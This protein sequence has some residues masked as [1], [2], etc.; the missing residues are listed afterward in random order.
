ME[1]VFCRA[2]ARV[3]SKSYRVA[4]IIL[5]NRHLIP[6][7][8]STVH[9][10]LGETVFVW[11][12]SLTLSVSKFGRGKGRLGAGNSAGRATRDGVSLKLAW[13]CWRIGPSLVP[14]LA[15]QTPA[16]TP[17]VAFACMHAPTGLPTMRCPPK[18]NSLARPCQQPMRLD[19]AL[20]H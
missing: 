4:K 6:P 7:E 3:P 20:A 5:K 17:R 14:G 9:Q 11:I 12:V 1:N 2:S 10:G 8:H 16:A 15:V 13:F 18:A 19:D